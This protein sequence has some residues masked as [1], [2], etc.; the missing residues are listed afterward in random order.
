M[1]SKISS[2]LSQLMGGTQRRNG[3][4]LMFR[5]KSFLLVQWIYVE[6]RCS[7]VR[8]IAMNYQHLNVN[9]IILR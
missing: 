6:E 8:N 7:Q 1:T 3:A 4:F 9:Q 2:L 5:G